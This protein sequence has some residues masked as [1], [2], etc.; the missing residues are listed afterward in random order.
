MASLFDESRSYHSD[1]PKLDIIGN[2]NTRA[3]W[4]HKEI[5]PPYYKLGRKVIYHGADLNAWAAANRVA[6]QNGD[7]G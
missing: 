6:P 7:A 5:G 3:Q 1:D 4:R 2:K